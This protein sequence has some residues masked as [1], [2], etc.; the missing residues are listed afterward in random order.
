[1][2]GMSGLKHSEETKRKISISHLGISHSIKTRLS[3]SQKLKG[4]IPWNKGKKL[5]ESYCKKISQSKIGNK[6]RVK[7]FN[8]DRN[9]YALIHQWVKRH[10][11][12]GNNCQFCNLYFEGYKIQYANKSGLYKREVEDWLILCSSCHAKY[13]QSFTQ[14]EIKN[15]R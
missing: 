6:N 15:G 5:S 4:N 9:E 2:A 11:E 13:D 7:I 8:G 12:K 3:I 10:K 14:E 1:M